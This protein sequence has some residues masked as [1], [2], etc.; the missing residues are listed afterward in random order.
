MGPRTRSGFVKHQ[1]LQ[2]CQADAALEHQPVG[3]RGSGESGEEAIKRVELV[4]LT[5]GAQLAAGQVLQV[6]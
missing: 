4:Q 3:V 5:G 2:D 1:L 6:G